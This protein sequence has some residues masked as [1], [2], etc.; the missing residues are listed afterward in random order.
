MR[1]EGAPEGGVAVIVSRPGA[2]VELKVRDHGPGM[3]PEQRARAFDR[4]W[5]SASSRRADGGFGLG[6]PI[7]RRLVLADGGDVRL[8]D[9]PGGGLAV[10]VSL[11]STRLALRASA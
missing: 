9:V 1:L 11:P 3:T 5:R 8:E 7:V 10:V 6:L 4:F 2:R